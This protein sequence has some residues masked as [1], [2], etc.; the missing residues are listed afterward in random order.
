MQIKYYITLLAEM[1]RYLVAVIMAVVMVVVAVVE[2]EEKLAVVE[3]QHMLL[4]LAECYQVLYQ[5]KMQY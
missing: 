1:V 4:L 5:I 2:P 3:A